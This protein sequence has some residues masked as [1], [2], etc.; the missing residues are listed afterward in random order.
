MMPTAEVTAN[1]QT[2]PELELERLS[3]EDRILVFANS[4]QACDRTARDVEEQR[5]LR[6]ERSAS[7]GR[8]RRVG[9]DRLREDA[10]VIRDGH[11]G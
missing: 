5:S 10:R 4:R 2:A 7:S 1:W 11:F 3:L 9:P 6:R 8:Q